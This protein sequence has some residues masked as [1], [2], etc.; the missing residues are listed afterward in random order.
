MAAVGGLAAD[1]KL[2]T[3]FL[4]RLWDAPIPTGRW[5]YYNGLLYTLALLEA[6]GR[7]QI[8]APACAR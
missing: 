7:F 6:G 3:P 1:P 8:H 2:A 5:R 4:Q